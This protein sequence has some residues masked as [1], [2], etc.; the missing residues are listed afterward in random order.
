[1]VCF[2]GNRVPPQRPGR[3][4]QWGTP[5]TTFF[6]NTSP[7]QHI[8]L[9]KH[10]SSTPISAETS[11]E[12]NATRARKGANVS[13]A[14]M[15]QKSTAVSVQRLHPFGLNCDR[16]RLSCRTESSYIYSLKQIL[17]PLH[18][19]R[20][21]VQRLEVQKALSCLLIARQAVSALEPVQSRHMREQSSMG[22]WAIAAF[23]NCGRC[24][25]R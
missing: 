19:R 2:R 17:H 13:I 22:F 20:R 7:K 15:F 1:M 3:P 9:P 8:I 6:L 25:W 14:F 18:A 24:M 5:Q 16:Q 11:T 23:Y 10:I 12:R 4:R 21:R